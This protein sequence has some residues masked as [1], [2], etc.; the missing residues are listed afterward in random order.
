MFAKAPESAVPTYKLILVG[1][2]GT[3]KTTFVKRHLY[4]EFDAKYNATIGVEIRPISFHTNQG[5]ICFNI[6]DTAGQ[7]KWGGLR[8]NYY[9]GSDCG[10]IMFD[11]TSRITY[12][13]VPNWY[14]DITKICPNLPLVICGNKV[15]V[16]ERKAYEQ[17]VLSFDQAPWPW[18]H[19]KKQQYLATPE[20]LAKAGFFFNPH[21]L[22]RDAVQCF[23]CHKSLDGWEAADDPF[24]EHLGH[25][26]ECPWALV[27]CNGHRVSADTQEATIREDLEDEYLQ[28]KTNVAVSR[29]LED[30]RVATYGNWWP[31]EGKTGWKVTIRK[32]AKSGYY[33]SP[34]T[35]SPD[36]ASCPYCGLSMD[37]WE[38]NDDPKKEHRK[39]SPGCLFFQ[40]GRNRAGTAQKKSNAS[41]SHPQDD[42]K[43]EESVPSDHLSRRSTRASTRSRAN[44][45]ASQIS[46]DGSEVEKPLRR[47]STRRRRPHQAM[48]SVSATSSPELGSHTSKRRRSNS[49][50]HAAAAAS[51][52]TKRPSLNHASDEPL[53][54]KMVSRGLSVPATEIDAVTTSTTDLESDTDSVAQTRTGGRRRGRGRGRGRTRAQPLRKSSIASVTF[55]TSR[56]SD[57]IFLSSVDM[58]DASAMDLD[59]E[60]KGVA[61]ETGSVVDQPEPVKPKQRRGQKPRA[62]RQTTRSQRS[63]RSSNVLSPDTS[64]LEDA[65][66]PRSASMAVAA[67]PALHNSPKSELE[68]EPEPRRSTR[69]SQRRRGRPTSAASTVSVGLSSTP[70]AA[71]Q[72]PVGPVV[73]DE[74]I[75]SAP[76]PTRQSKQATT[77][78]DLIDDVPVQVAPIATTVTMA[79]AQGVDESLDAVKDQKPIRRRNKKPSRPKKRSATANRNPSPPPSPALSPIKPLTNETKV[80]PLASSNAAS[81][82]EKKELQQTYPLPAPRSAS[83]DGT[84]S[85]YSN[86]T[87]TIPNDNAPSPQR[88]F[89]VPQVAMMNPLPGSSGSGAA[90]DASQSMQS[91]TE[92]PPAPMSP[93]ACDTTTDIRMGSSTQPSP[94]STTAIISSITSLAPTLTTAEAAVATGTA[95]IAPA[96]RP[97]RNALLFAD[98]AVL[99]TEISA[100]E[101]DM[102]VEQFIRHT[103]QQECTRLQSHCS[104]RIEAF[105]QE[106]DAVRDKIQAL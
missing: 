54:A 64:M 14:R 23:L 55:T 61:S 29:R 59:T 89:P 3:G 5:P 25:S 27:I 16:P 66:T 60:P 19:R 46:D 53:G 79:E 15:D 92:P 22:S 9:T 63:T 106:A 18:P 76:H 4:G 102:S 80:Q 47:Q 6:Y 98:P 83:L 8:D 86:H 77:V 65:A 101:A 12:K 32:M 45:L 38:P 7:E 36:A 82:P 95:R 97:S 50:D 93:L 41:Q 28:G 31:H 52:E 103:I 67:G 90:L 42:D 74:F 17:R 81:S 70:H 69:S 49:M 26:G 37:Y 20:T 84:T 11:V 40:R 96:P 24:V 94:V 87:P 88:L 48:E 91:A 58:V 99:L 10:I 104:D 85:P 56:L 2:G 30:A 34:S 35:E 72:D 73:D 43:I 39:R 68:I 75:S 71:E 105:K 13:N 51:P 44:S 100:A 78:P 62:A 1:D 57:S 21:Q 33:Y